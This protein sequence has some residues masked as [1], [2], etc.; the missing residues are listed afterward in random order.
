LCEGEDTKR[1]CLCRVIK[2]WWQQNVCI[3]L[4]TKIFIAQKIALEHA[5]TYFFKKSL[6]L[7]SKAI[8]K[9]R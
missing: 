3:F 5:A 7:I 9:I 6:N 8:Q 2:G 4:C 1:W